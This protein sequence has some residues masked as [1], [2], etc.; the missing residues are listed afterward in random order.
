MA[1]DATRTGKRGEVNGPALRLTEGIW[2][3]RSIRVPPSVRP[4]ASRPRQALVNILRENYPDTLQEACILD[5]FA[6]SGAV[7]LEFL[8]AFPNVRSCYFV[9]KNA[10]VARQ[11]EHNCRQ[12]GAGERSLVFTGPLERFCLPHALERP[13]LLFLDPPY[14]TVQSSD[15]VRVLFEHLTANAVPSRQGALVILQTTPSVRL[16][17]KTFA[18]LDARQYGRGLFYFA[19]LSCAAP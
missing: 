12:L 2:R 16:S 19:R 17:E 3:R 15:D 1:R 8:S 10:R 18:L 5:G 7:G 4:T 9:E 13:R 11:L 14:A 6:G